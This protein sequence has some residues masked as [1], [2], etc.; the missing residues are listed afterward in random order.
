[1]TPRRWERWALIAGPVLFGLIGAALGK[2]S[3]GGGLTGALFVAFAIFAVA[4]EAPSIVAWRRALPNR[5]QIY[6]IDI[7]GC[8]LIAGW[9]IA[10]VMAAAPAGNGTHRADG[11]FH[12]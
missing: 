2:G 9:I 3:G 11:V 5:V 8:W 6:L 12:E 7:L 4:A 10:L 1:M